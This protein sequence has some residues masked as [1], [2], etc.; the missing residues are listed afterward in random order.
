MSKSVTK[1]SWLTKRKT[2]REVYTKLATDVAAAS[3]ALPRPA[4]EEDYWLLLD[5][6]GI[7]LT[8]AQLND[9]FEDRARL[10]VFINKMRGLQVAIRDLM[11][12]PSSVPNPEPRRIKKKSNE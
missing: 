12:P 2:R 3:Y 7:L 4:F 9:T 5:I 10:N 8:V 6:S 1:R 11:P